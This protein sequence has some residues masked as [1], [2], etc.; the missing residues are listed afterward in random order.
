MEVVRVDI[1][2]SELLK[3]VEVDLPV[4]WDRKPTRQCTIKY[5]K[6]S[7][8]FVMADIRTGE[9]QYSYSRLSDLVRTTNQIYDYNDVAIEDVEEVL[10]Q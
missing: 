10:A 6:E 9:V 5:D 1:K 2:A 3:G 8:R 7:K 4:E